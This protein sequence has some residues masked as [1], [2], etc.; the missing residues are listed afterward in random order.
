MAFGYDSSLDRGTA[1]HGPT[2]Y[3]RPSHVNA[4]RQFCGEAECAGW[5]RTRSAAVAESGCDAVDRQMDGAPGA[6]VVVASAITTQQ[7]DLQMI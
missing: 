3:Q 2:Q 7:L 5:R 1:A 6:H 4:G